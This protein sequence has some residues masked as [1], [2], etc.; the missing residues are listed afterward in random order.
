MKFG[1]PI[2]MLAHGLVGLGIYHG[3]K[4]ITKMEPQERIVT[5]HLAT[6]DEITN[7]RASVKKTAPKPQPK[8]IPEDVP[9]TLQT[10]MENAE[11]EG[12]PE[13]RTVEEKPAPQVTNDAE[14]KIKT[15]EETREASNEVFNIDEISAVVNRSRD[16]QPIAGQ[17]KTLLSEQNFYRYSEQSQAAA[18]AGTA[19][20]MSEQDALQSRM[21]ECWSEPVGA[22][23][24]QELIVEVRVKMRRDGTII[25]AY[26]ND[27]RAVQ[28][29]LNPFMPIAARNAVNAVKKCSPYDFMPVEKYSQWQDM[30]LTF[31]PPEV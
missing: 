25:D 6:I 30:V 18:G 2:S 23:N 13:K 20:T 26:L 17:Q 28:R 8:P 29:S 1:V 5:V 31:I 11:E 27:Q 22:P 12:D 21:Y 24:P 16:S 15:T 9:M 7:V 14:E 3:F 4:T 10:P 19:L